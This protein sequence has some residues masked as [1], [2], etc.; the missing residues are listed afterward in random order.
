MEIQF[1]AEII[2]NQDKI[3]MTVSSLFFDVQLIFYFIWLPER[4]D[5]LDSPLTTISSLTLSLPTLL[6]FSYLIY[7]FFADGFPKVHRINFLN[8]LTRAFLLTFLKQITTRTEVP[9]STY[10]LQTSSL[11]ELRDLG[12]RKSWFIGYIPILNMDIYLL[13]F[14]FFFPLY[15]A[16]CCL[17]NIK[18]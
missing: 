9:S 16:F 18:G 7:D 14:V 4:S 5:P 15:L 3:G 11:W 12:Y 8:F 17:C 1:G 10:Y 6:F 13:E 2:I